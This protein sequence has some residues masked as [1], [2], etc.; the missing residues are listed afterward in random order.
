MRLF[1][2]AGGAGRGGVDFWGCVARAHY[3]RAAGA[4]RKSR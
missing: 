3:L 1:H 2:A 4:S